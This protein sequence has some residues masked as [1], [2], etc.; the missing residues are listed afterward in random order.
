MIASHAYLQVL[1]DAIAGARARRE[2]LLLRG[3]GT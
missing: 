1:V 2:P 3:G